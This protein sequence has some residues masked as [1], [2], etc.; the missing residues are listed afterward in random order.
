MSVTGWLMLVLAAVVPTSCARGSTSERS[1]AVVFVV[2]SDPGI[3]IGRAQVFVD[4]K[5]IGKTDPDG[6]VQM[7]IVGQP[8]QLLRVEHDC[9]DGHEDPLEPKMLRLRSFEGVDPSSTLAMEI[10]L[11][12]PPE[13][14]LAA[15]IVRA[16]NGSDLPVLLDGEKVART[17]GSGVAHFSASGAVGTEYVIELDTTE[18]PQLLPQF[19][20][21]LFTL[22]DAD[23]I[24]MVNQPF[25]LEKERPRRRHHW[26]RI[27]KI[28]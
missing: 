17:N 8:R 4:R 9:P 2:E 24:F 16:K 27:T 18:R 14:R 15:F 7:K 3:R 13:K 26:S 25:D 21:H 5:P 11:R 19:P 6:V 22:P 28:E 1:F 12:C 20:T 23:E 10:T